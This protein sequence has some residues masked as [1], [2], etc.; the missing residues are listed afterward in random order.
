MTVSGHL[1]VRITATLFAVLVLVVST[2]GLFIGRLAWALDDEDW[3]WIT[4]VSSTG[5]LVGILILS[6]TWE[7][8]WRRL[9]ATI[10][11]TGGSLLLGWEALSFEGA[12]PFVVIAGLAALAAGAALLLWGRR[13]RP[14]IAG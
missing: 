10:L 14:S 12:R 3:A 8:T 1:P 2:Y 6:A 11:M 7:L 5:V 9:A 13:E 4:G